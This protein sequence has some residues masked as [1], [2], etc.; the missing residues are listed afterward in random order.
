MGLG[1]GFKLKD[2]KDKERDKENVNIKD[3]KDKPKLKHKDKDREK[4]EE[5]LHHEVYASSGWTSILEDWLCNGIGSIANTKPSGLYASGSPPDPPSNR[6]S[7]GNLHERVAEKEQW[8]GP[9]QPLIKHRMMGLYL[10]VYIHRDIRS[11]VR[12]KYRSHR[13]SIP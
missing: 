8:K 5:H 7:G 1:A 6:L 10:T 13:C 2:P 3:I 4:N 11:L 9:Y 12:G